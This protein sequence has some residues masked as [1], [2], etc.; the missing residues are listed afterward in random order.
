MVVLCLALDHWSAYSCSSMRVRKTSLSTTFC[1][2]KSSLL[3]DLLASANGEGLSVS[4][5]SALALQALGQEGASE[6]EEPVRA[7]QGTCPCWNAACHGGLHGARLTARGWCG[8]PCAG[9]RPAAS[10]TPPGRARVRPAMGDGRRGRVHSSLTTMPCCSRPAHPPMKGV[11]RCHH[12]P[13]RPP[14]PPRPARPPPPPPPR[15]SRP[16]RSA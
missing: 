5:G 6:R 7:P 4:S 11:S 1:R 3:S 10:T 2:K 12:C 15:G 8:D 13:S 9:A 14:P 16:W